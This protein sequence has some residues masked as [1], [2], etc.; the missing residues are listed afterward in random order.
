MPLLLPS[1]FFRN[2]NEK[3]GSDQKIDKEDVVAYFK[4]ELKMIPIF[5]GFKNTSTID[6]L[7]TILER[8]HYCLDI[9]IPFSTRDGD[10][11]KAYE[12]GVQFLCRLKQDYKLDVDSKGYNWITAKISKNEIFLEFFELL[13]HLLDK[14][15]AFVYDEIDNNDTETFIHYLL[16]TYCNLDQSPKTVGF[17][18]MK[19]LY[20]FIDHHSDSVLPWYNYEIQIPDDIIKVHTK[21]EN[22]VK[23]T[24]EPIVSEALWRVLSNHS[25]I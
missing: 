1:F 16:Q 23:D 17:I 3:C 5:T 2:E 12:E 7:Y 6:N 21:F 22:L 14:N 4:N 24:D 13:F 25:Y 15:A 8:E 11:C 10:E 9:M 18:R 19:N 20:D